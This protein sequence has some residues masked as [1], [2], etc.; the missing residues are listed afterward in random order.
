MLIYDRLLRPQPS[1]P[2]EARQAR[3]EPNMRHL[4]VLLAALALAAAIAGTATAGYAKGDPRK[5]G[6]PAG[7]HYCAQESAKISLR[8]YM[9]A[10][11]GFPGTA[12]WDADITCAQNGKT[13]L[14]WRC[15][16]HN[17]AGSGTATVWFRALSTGWHRVVTVTPT[18]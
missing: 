3:K 9:S 16:F 4:T 18:P 11:E 14:K 15:T 7:A 17:G 8:Y 1:N 13:L 6:N 10:K 12:R 2:V 5:C